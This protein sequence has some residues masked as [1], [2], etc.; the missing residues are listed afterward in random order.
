MF[1]IRRLLEQADIVPI[2]QPANL[3]AGAQAGDWVSMAGYDRATIVFMKARG[4]E[5]E[6]PTLTLE[7]AQDADSTGAKALAIPELYA[8]GGLGL[9][10][11]EDFTKFA[12][13]TENTWTHG[14]FAE[15]D[16]CIVIEIS[17]EQLDRDHG[18]NHIRLSASDPGNTAQWACGIAIMTGAR[19]GG[20]SLMS[21]IV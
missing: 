1:P 8:K 15:W 12:P 17:A 6:D 21:A 7:Q 16:W 20:A 11:T 10:L 9:T 5:G 13:S 19:Y 18:F 3:S 4:A 2:F 14:N